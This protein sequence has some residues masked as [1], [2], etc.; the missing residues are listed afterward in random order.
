MRRRP[1]LVDPVLRA[2]DPEAA[3]GGKVAV[4]R[5]EVAGEPQDRGGGDCGVGREVCGCEGVRDCA[6]EC[7]CEWGRQRGEERGPWLGAEGAGGEQRE[8][9]VEGPAA[10]RGGK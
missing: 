5:E 3:G 8:R 2:R 9:R 10:R 6:V 1:G 4:E 7:V